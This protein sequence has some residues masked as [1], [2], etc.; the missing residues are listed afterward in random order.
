MLE[1]DHD[2]IQKLPESERPP[3][4]LIQK[5][6]DE[7]V[8]KTIQNLFIV[9]IQNDCTCHIEK[10]AADIDMKYVF[11]SSGGIKIHTLGDQI[12]LPM[13]TEISNQDIW[14]LLEIACMNSSS[15]KKYPF[16]YE[17]VLFNPKS[18]IEK[19][20]KQYE[21]Y[22]RRDWTSYQRNWVSASFVKE[23]CVYFVPDPEFFG[24]I[25]ANIDKFGCF[26]IADSILKV[27]I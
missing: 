8:S 14:K 10:Y 11:F 1:E 17:R 12:K 27:I 19:C 2:S 3:Y 15:L 13:Q 5:R 21:K 23:D 6:L 24:V 7:R 4:S 18:N 9:D 26:C 16:P 22:C 25:S 20:I